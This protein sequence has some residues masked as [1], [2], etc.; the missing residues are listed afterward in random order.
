[1]AVAMIN[2]FGGVRFA[3]NP[4][5]WNWNWL[6]IMVAA[7][8]LLFIWLPRVILHRTQ[9][10]SCNR[11]DPLKTTMKAFPQ[12]PTARLLTLS[13]TD[14]RKLRQNFDQ[15]Q[16]GTRD[17]EDVIRKAEEVLSQ[18]NR[19]DQLAERS[20]RI[21][22][23][24]QTVIDRTVNAM[25][26]ISDS[27]CRINEI[28]GAI[29]SIAFQTNLLALN[30]SVEAA[31]AG[32]A[33][34]GFAVVADEV[35][36]LARRAADQS[37]QSRR[38][39]QEAIDRISSG[40]KLVTDAR[41]AF[42]D[43]SSQAIEMTKIV[44][45]IQTSS[46]SQANR[47]NR[48]NYAIMRSSADSRNI[49]RMRGKSPNSL[50][51]LRFRPQWVPQSQFAGYYVAL[52]KGFYRDLGLNVE[53]LDGGPESNPPS[54][55]VR[56]EIE[57]GTAW[58]AP[59]L[60]MS[61]RGADLVLLSQ[62]IQKNGLLLVTMRKQGFKKIEDLK[63]RRVGVWGGEFDYPLLALDLEKGLGVE[64]VQQ[65]FDMSEVIDAKV[66]AA[67][68]MSFNEMFIFDDR[69]IDRDELKI[70]RFQN[71]GLNFPEDGLYTSQRIWQSEPDACRRFV[72][73]SMAGWQYAAANIEEALDIVMAHAERSPLPT[74]RTHQSRMLS[75]IIQ[76]INLD[77]AR[78][79]QL[80]QEV[81]RQVSKALQNIGQIDRPVAFEQFYKGDETKAAIPQK[82]V[83]PEAAGSDGST[84]RN[85]RSLQPSTSP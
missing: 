52:D 21:A 65:G 24:G 84:R 45:Q 51:K 14:L 6:G 44:K 25:A 68:S 19:A 22:A 77:S 27:S 40:E 71:L 62:F 13:T 82:V 17:L 33:G 72:R 37:N 16:I 85:R 1:M 54:E 3:G 20:G 42:N 64:L 10:V 38:L 55:L 36:N 5:G 29:E 46:H 41:G 58:L 34:G 11:S 43:L 74:T 12:T 79:G 76:M 73:A 75:E 4:D 56:G 28:I 61:S 80:D 57:F 7:D 18:I 31:R 9:T 23:S 49:I 53:F 35:R 66:D 60:V 30:A 47:F 26:T 67:L 59:S 69:G 32:E 48:L 8:L 39:I 50:R 81:F 63:G 83:G 78:K 70:F 15:I 2:M